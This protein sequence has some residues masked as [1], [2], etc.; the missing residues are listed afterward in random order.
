MFY[1][2][3]LSSC[4]R[5]VIWAHRF[6]KMT[7]YQHQLIIAP[8]SWS[9]ARSAAQCLH[10]PASR[11]RAEQAID[12][13]EASRTDTSRTTCSGS[14]FPRRHRVLT[15]G[16]RNK[17]WLGVAACQWHVDTLALSWPVKNANPHGLV[18]LPDLTHDEGQKL[19][20]RCSRALHS[21]SSTTRRAAI[22][23]FV[24]KFLHNHVLRLLLQMV[25]PR[26][27]L[28]RVP[29]TDTNE[30]TTW[31]CRGNSRLDHQ[32]LFSSKYTILFKTHCQSNTD[33]IR[34]FA[35][36]RTIVNSL[37]RAGNKLLA[38]Q[39]SLPSDHF[40]SAFAAAVQWCLAF[41]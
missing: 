18:L 20:N 7:E 1:R 40:A 30:H 23:W 35:F 38:L 41:H 24:C 25:A 17:R 14:T 9:N 31:P 32:N 37:T 16:F 15:H 6:M 39:G 34:H 12:L 29:R 19:T 22:S 2:V 10:G 4:S 36:I 3:H 5:L 13:L 33:E 11:L 28:I 27:I 8:W 26:R 21:S